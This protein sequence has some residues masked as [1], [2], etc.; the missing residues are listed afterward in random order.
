VPL[1]QAYIAKGPQ[2][3]P[4]AE[5][6]LLRVIEDNPL[7]TPEAQ[8][9]R[10]ALFELAQLYYRT[11]RFE[12]AVAR[13]VELTDRYP[14]DE[15]RGQ[16]LFMMAD[17][18]RKSAALLNVNL[19]NVAV[20]GNAPPAPAAVKPGENEAAAAKR[21]RLAKARGFYDKVIELYRDNAP[22][23]E[24]DRLQLK[25][26]HFYR[27][28]CVYDLGRY[29]EAIKLYDAA[30]L[31]YQDDSSSLAAYV[32]IVNSYCALGKLD[33]AKTANERAKWLLR[34]MPEGA[35]RDG[36]FS[37]PKAYWEQWLKWTGNTGLFASNDERN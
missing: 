13:L 19:A 28:D 3:Y 9:F 17:S 20:G 16:V 22:V 8:E 25:L 32:Q 15:R 21:D 34:K 26:S 2:S 6:A 37:M 27:A 12:E 31:K 18:Y 4:S 10:E 1:A 35:F 33:E 30:A 11:D 29:D 24:I 36:S 14:Q 23:R 7:I 5:A